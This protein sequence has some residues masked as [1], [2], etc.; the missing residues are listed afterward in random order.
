ME[1]IP[2][3]QNDKETIFDFYDRKVNKISDFEWNN[4]PFQAISPCEVVHEGLLHELEDLSKK[5]EY[6]YFIATRN[7]LIKYSIDVLT[8]DNKLSET[9]K[10]YLR[11]FFPIIKAIKNIEK[12]VYGF[13]LI[14]KRRIH[15]FFN[16][17]KSEI[18][19]WFIKLKNICLLTTLHIDFELKN[20]IG[21]G[22]FST[23]VHAIN[24][25][26]KKGYAI[27][28][29]FLENIK[30]KISHIETIKNEIKILKMLN[31]PNIIRLYDV[32]YSELSISLVF[33]YLKGGELFEYIEKRKSF[34]EEEAK[35]IIKKLLST[36]KYLHDNNVIHR[37]LKP[38]NILCENKDE[39]LSFKI[40][41]FCLS[42]IN[43]ENEIQYI[44]CGSPGFVAP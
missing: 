44:R 42:V 9:P 29:I 40:A 38:E 8:S 31:H 30:N 27:K 26:D 6:F 4:L 41:D 5:E 18:R 33:E 2:N 34:T 37:D 1:S 24:K 20:T 11:I 12:N 32:Y 36:I 14:S 21:S 28:T 13:S 25:N 23:V 17:T 39:L 22:N 10:E 15:N 16:D 35:K 7:F 3:P 43:R 19:T